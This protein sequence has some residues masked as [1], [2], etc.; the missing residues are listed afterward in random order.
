MELSAKG[1]EFIDNLQLYLMASGKKDAEINEIVEELTDHLIEAEK[2]GKNITEIT[3]DSPKAYMESLANEMKTDYREWLKYIPLVF[4]SVIAYKVIG[5]TLLGEISYSL[6]V[7]IGQPLVVAVMLL[8]F[9]LTFKK[10]ASNTEA[11]SK[12]MMIVVMILNILCTS[13]F[14]LLLYFGNKG[15]PVLIIDNFAGKLGVAAVAF[16][17]LAWFAWWSKSLLPFIPLMIY[18]PTLAVQYLPLTN[19][20]KAIYSAILFALFGTIYFLVIFIK[21]RKEKAK[22]A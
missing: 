13:A 8:L 4:I 5:D 21:S 19:E 14:V 20:E 16:V 1:Q 10:F 11:L 7:I 12:K 3:G 2:D 22:T 17:F 15:T 6:A 18:V 9:V